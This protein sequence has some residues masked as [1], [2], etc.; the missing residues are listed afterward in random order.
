MLDQARFHWIHPNIINLLRILIRI[1][2][3]VLVVALLPDFAL[4]IHL[5]FCSIGESP[6]D[7]LHCF[8][9]RHERRRRENQM[10]VVSHEDELVD[11]KSL[12]GPVFTKYVEQEVAKVVRLE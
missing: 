3:P 11:L 8:L 1:S 5:L 7:E 10:D 12:F 6:F 2:D 9:E 4:E